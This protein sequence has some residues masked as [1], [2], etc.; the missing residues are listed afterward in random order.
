MII[1]KV[2][3]CPKE[4]K[5]AAPRDWLKDIR[6][7]KGYSHS[8]IAENCS[9]SRPF[10]SSVEAGVKNPSVGTAKEIAQILDFPWTKFFE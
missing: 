8:K 5:S 7:Q 6:N 3:N 1:I 4:N 2:L 10:Y 9:F